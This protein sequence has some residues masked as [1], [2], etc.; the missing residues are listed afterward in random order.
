MLSGYMENVAHL[1]TKK[2]TK[3]AP[4]LIKGLWFLK[5][6]IDKLSNERLNIATGREKKVFLQKEP[7]GSMHKR[8]V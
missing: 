6:T 4:K 3:L 5:K 7:E 2:L 1:L 8:Y